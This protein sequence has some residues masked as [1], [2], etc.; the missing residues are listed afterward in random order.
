MKAK[1]YS[2]APGLT[3]L[4]NRFTTT[5]VTLPSGRKVKDHVPAPAVLRVEHG[6]SSSFFQRTRAGQWTA[7]LDD[8]VIAVVDL[9]DTAEPSKRA[10]D[11]GT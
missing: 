11:L 3:I 6:S 5:E 9:F 4:F 2:P 1:T 10:P 7:M 8:E